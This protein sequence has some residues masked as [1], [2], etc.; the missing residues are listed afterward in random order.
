M[1][2]NTDN[3]E[4][5]EQ[6]AAEVEPQEPTTEEPET[7]Q[8]EGTEEDADT[9]PR[10]VVEDLRKEAAK[11]RDRAKAAD[12]L[13]E[14]LWQARVAATGRLADPTDLALPD[15][16]DPLDPEAVNAAVE[17]LLGRKPHLAARAVTGPVGA[18]ESGGSGDAVDLAGILRARA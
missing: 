6:E 14:A 8:E 18:G 4:N 1:S 3:I 11:Y 15:D 5:T 7:T 10:S 13:R 2:D 12:D 9:F 16:A 17:D